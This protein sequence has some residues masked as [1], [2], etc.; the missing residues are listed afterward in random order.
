MSTTKIALVIGLTILGLMGAIHYMK[1]GESPMIRISS[2]DIALGDREYLFKGW[3]KKYEKSY[4]ADEQDF[5]YSVWS[6]SFDTVNAHN[7]KGLSWTLETNKFADLTNEEFS[8][9]YLGYK[10]NPN[11]VREN[12]V[13]LD[14]SNTP[15][16]VDWRKKGA[17]TGVKDQGQCG[18]CYTFSSSGALEGLY[19][20]KKGSLV[21]FS[22][23]QLLDCTSSGGN[24]GCDGGLMD[25]CFKYT[26][27]K[28]IEKEADY[29]YTG[30]AGTCAYS[31][32]KTVY[33]NT[34]YTDVPANDFTQ[35]RA[36]VK[37]QPVSVAVEADQDAWK[38][39]KSGIISDNC[40]TTLDH[41][42]LTVGYGSNFWIVKN[43]W[44]ASWGESGYL[45]I[46]SGS[47]NN[48]AGVCGIN[49]DS[50]YPT[51]A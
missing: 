41:G 12:V 18:S 8:A 30:K 17:V 24:Q 25:N 6:K 43:S 40:G 50:S 20:I 22:E 19:F 42:V 13:Y 37:G 36:A 4:S 21:S 51:L 15:A 39:Y 28:G 44:G 31:A 45:R 2:D 23:Q 10:A 7:A 33:K 49:S 47:Q 38:L 46:A 14:D 48:G 32:S 3:M 29:G 5:R 35:L 27:S 26:Q 9:L 34:G 1:T 11:R 16:G